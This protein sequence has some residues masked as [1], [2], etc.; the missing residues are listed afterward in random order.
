MDK[1]SLAYNS[2]SR[3]ELPTPL[4]SD[5]PLRDA[6]KCGFQHRLPSLH[7]SHEMLIWGIRGCLNTRLVGMWKPHG[8]WYRWLQPACYMI[9]CHGFKSN[10]TQQSRVFITETYVLIFLLLPI[11]QP[12]PLSLL[13]QEEQ[14][15]NT[16]QL[17]RITLICSLSLDARG[18]TPLPYA[19]DSLCWRPHLK[20]LLY[21]SYRDV[22]IAHRLAQAVPVS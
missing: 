22:G 4:C 15:D 11:T 5:I 20:Y 9:W 10:W 7:G 6:L 3:L 18:S 1:S 8:G 21:L 16:A 12:T 2:P 13:S 14:T 19:L 17:V